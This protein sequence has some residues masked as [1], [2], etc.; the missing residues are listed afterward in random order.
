MIHQN[1]LL[2]LPFSDIRG[3]D[4]T[5]S[6][7]IVYITEAQNLDISLIKLAIQR[8]SEDCQLIIDGDYNSQ[9]DLQAFEG[10][11]NGMRRVSEVFRGQSFYGEVE[12]PIIYRSK[13][14]EWAEKFV[15]KERNCEM[16]KN[17]LCDNC[18]HANV[19]VRKCMCCRNS[20]MKIIHWY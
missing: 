12:L 4:T 1:K 9:V 16:I 10:N 20:M 7:A 5:N 3:F 15:N 2:L 13:M 18:K 14:A 19:F 17:C 6:K 11:N 8:I